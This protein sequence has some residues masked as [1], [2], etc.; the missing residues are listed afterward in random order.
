VAEGATMSPV[1]AVI[2]IAM[3]TATER[4][5]VLMLDNLA[6]RRAGPEDNPGSALRGTAA[7]GWQ[8]GRR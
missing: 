6:R 5:R 8:T 3:N 4:R 7:C 2:S 1:R